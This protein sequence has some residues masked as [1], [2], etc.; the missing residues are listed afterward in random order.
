MA[1]R[2]LSW[3]MRPGIWAGLTMIGFAAVFVTPYCSYLFECGCTWPW[4]GLDA[5][6]NI[7]NRQA[8]HRC[9]WCISLEAG[10]A[11]MIALFGASYVAAARG[12]GGAGSFAGGYG[13]GL[14]FGIGAFLIAGF[15]SAWAAALYTGYPSFIISALV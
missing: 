14:M 3:L 1:T 7:H 6:C 10:A 5:D 13:R 9:P 2:S 11:S 8:L 15:L 4:A 12:A